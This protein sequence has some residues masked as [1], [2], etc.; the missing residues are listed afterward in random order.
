MKKLAQ[1]HTKTEEVKITQEEAESLIGFINAIQAAKLKL[2][3]VELEKHS[4]IAEIKS[5]EQQYNDYDK[6]ISHKYGHGVRVDLATRVVTKQDK[7]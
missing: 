1:T 2:A 5:I 7:N 3:S 4:I 6:L